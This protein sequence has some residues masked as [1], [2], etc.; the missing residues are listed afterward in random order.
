MGTYV[1]IMDTHGCSGIYAY[2]GNA[3]KHKTLPK[4]A[5][6]SIFDN[7]RTVQKNGADFGVTKK[8]NGEGGG[9][10]FG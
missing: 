4:W 7:T 3:K 6:M 9:D 10:N 5:R 2:E 1:V 8:S